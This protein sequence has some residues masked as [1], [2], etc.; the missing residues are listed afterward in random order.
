MFPFQTIPSRPNSATSMCVTSPAP[1]FY[2]IKCISRKN[3]TK[4]TQDLLVNEIKILKHIKHENIVQMYDFQVGL[5]LPRVR[6]ALSVSSSSGMITISTSS[7]STAPAVTCPCSYI[8]DGNS[9]KLVLDRLYSRSVSDCHARSSLA[10]DNAV[11]SQANA[12]KFLH[13]KQISHMDL[14]P[15]NILL[16]SVDRPVV[17]IAGKNRDT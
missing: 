9:R 14:K 5:I 15:S 17:K 6:H 1:Q 13:A 3:L 2:A 4:T 10:V 11:V 16:T 7:W 12:L 8:P